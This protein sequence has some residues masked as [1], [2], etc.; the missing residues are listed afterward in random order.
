M[1]PHY[2]TWFAAPV[3]FFSGLSTPTAKANSIHFSH[4]TCHKDIK[5]GGHCGGEGLGAKTQQ[6]IRV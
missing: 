4:M 6:V 2:G 3:F 5:Q 1:F